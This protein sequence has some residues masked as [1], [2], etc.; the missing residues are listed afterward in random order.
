MRWAQVFV[1]LGRGGVLHWK[2][3]GHVDDIGVLVEALAH[4]VF[5]K[6]FFSSVYIQKIIETFEVKVDVQNGTLMF[7]EKV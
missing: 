3:K 2:P 4:I 1:Q 6:E 5:T 7:G